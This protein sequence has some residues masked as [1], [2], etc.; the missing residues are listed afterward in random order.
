MNLSEF[1]AQCEN[2]AETQL[3]LLLDIIVR[4]QNCAFGRKY[5]FANIKTLADFRKNVP[6]TD[7]EDL[8]PYSLEASRGVPNQL[9]IGDPEL[10]IISSGTTGREKILPESSAGLQAKNLTTSLRMEVLRKHFPKITQGKILPLVNKAEFGKTECGIPFGSASGVTLLQ[11]PAALRSITAYPLPVLEIA[12]SAAMDYAIM[13]FSLM[14]DVRL[15]IGN[16]AGRMEQL[17]TL[18]KENS[19]TIIDDIRNGTLNK[20][21]SISEKI[22]SSLKPFLLPNPERATQ[23]EM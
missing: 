8:E 13:R 10:F 5:G 9:F 16:N 2:C 1:I 3:N 21:F 11:A 12:D 6:I 20:E 4:N 15:I 7:W 23:L 22:R 17:V 18:A 14:E 19:R